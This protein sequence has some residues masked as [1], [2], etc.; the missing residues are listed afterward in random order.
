MFFYIF[1]LFDKESPPGSYCGGQHANLAGK[2]CLP[3]RACEVTPSLQGRSSYILF[4]YIY[5]ISLFSF[6][7][8]PQSIPPP[9]AGGGGSYILF[10]FPHSCFFSILFPA[11]LF[12]LIQSG[13]CQVLNPSKEG[14]SLLMKPET[15]CLCNTIHQFI[16][17]MYG[18]PIHSIY[19]IIRYSIPNTIDILAH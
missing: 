12:F 17:N 4:Y 3:G 1:P 14:P 16:F 13:F 6:G 19:N 11:E 8:F 7:F 10:L 5:P 15:H 2:L 18:E 9:G